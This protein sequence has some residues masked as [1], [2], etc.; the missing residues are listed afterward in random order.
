MLIEARASLVSPGTE[1]RCLEGR[2]DKGTKWSGWVQYPFK[3]GYSLAGTVVKPGKDVSQFQPGDRIVAML[4][5]AQYSL[6]RADNLIRVPE[7]VSWE[8]AAWQPL[9]VVAQ[10]GARR[11]EVQLGE[12][13]GIIG[14]GPLGQLAIQYVKLCGARAIV[15]IDP[16]EE[17]LE[18]AKKNG[19]RHCLAMSADT[20][21]AEVRTLTSGRMLDIVFDVTG[22]PM[23]LSSATQMVRRS[24]K[25]VL[26]GD[27]TMPSQQ[28]LGPNVVSDSIS[29]LGTHGSHVPSVATEFN[30]WTWKEMSGLFFELLIDKRLDVLSLTTGRHSPLDAQKVYASLRDQVAGQIGIVF[31][32]SL[33]TGDSR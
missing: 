17:R 32:W 26:L 30:P 11:A 22:L 25:V 28:F 19:A 18:V 15:V 14:A 13:V 1:L 29:I 5:H 27:N 16:R 23:V 24:G 21:V 6:D 10:I 8:E 9:A 31:D 12:L 4:P 20:A 33:V 7:G 2:F 3:P